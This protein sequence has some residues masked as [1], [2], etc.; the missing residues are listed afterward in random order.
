MNLTTEELATRWKMSPQTLEN[1]RSQGIGPK[2]IKLGVA[3]SSLVIYRLSDIE[4]WEH[5]HERNGL[6]QVKS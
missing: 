2:Y 3:K 4:K 6:Y 5:K 1:W